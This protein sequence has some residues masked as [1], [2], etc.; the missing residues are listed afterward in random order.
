MTMTQTVTLAGVTRS[1]S[2]LDNA[3]QLGQSVRQPGIITAVH[4]ATWHM[5][6][7]IEQL[8]VLREDAVKQMRREEL[9]S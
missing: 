5:A 1:L 3:F 4:T 2:Q 7:V 9:S 6:G 8:R